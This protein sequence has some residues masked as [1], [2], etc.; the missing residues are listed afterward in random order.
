MEMRTF[1][2]KEKK[3]LFKRIGEYLGQKIKMLKVDGTDYTDMCRELNTDNSKLTHLHQ[4]GILSEPLLISF[5]GSGMAKIDEISDGVAATGKEKQFLEDNYR[6]YENKAY[7][8]LIN[9]IKKKGV[10]DATIIRQLEKLL[11]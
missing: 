9:K 8:K 2:K 7:Q 1:T 3:E 6:L 11:D 10:S 5:I 4:K